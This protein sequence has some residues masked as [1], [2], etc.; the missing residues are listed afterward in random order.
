MAA[1][2]VFGL[3][4]GSFLNVCIYRMPRG[5]SVVA[6]RS[7]CPACKRPIA[8]YD[9]IPVISWLLLGGRCRHCKTSI[10]PRYLGVELLT[11]ILFAACVWVFGPSLAAVK[12]VTL[13]FLL[14][15][16]IFTDC[17]NRLLPDLL[18]IPGFFL[19]LGFSLIVPLNGLFEYLYA[20]NLNWRLLSLAD[21]LLAALIGGGFVWGAGE[22]YFRMRGI[23]GMGFGDVKLLLL[24][25]AFVGARMTVLT[26]FA[27]SVGAAVIGVAMFP[28]VYN[29]R[30]KAL[31]LK[32]RF[33]DEKERRQEAYDS[34]MRCMRLPFGSFLGAAALFATFFGDRIANWYMG[35]YR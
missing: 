6:P 25:G 31:S 5:L 24:I 16:L 20:A 35:L 14:L 22:L 7:A 8:A 32:R 29:R 27:A 12:F 11:G 18:T 19:G 15:G 28:A 26:I 30:K 33:D 21:A 34:A 17:E 3:V 1:A 2:F 9:N 13:S 10:S 4:L 23:A